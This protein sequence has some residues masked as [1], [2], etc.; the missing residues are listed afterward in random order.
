[1]NSVTEQNS[2]PLSA[3]QIKKRAVGSFVSMLT[4]EGIVGLITIGGGW[5]LALWLSPADFGTFA[6]IQFLG[7]L[8]AF[9][10]EIGFGGML[11]RKQTEPESGELATIFTLQMAAVLSFALL[12]FLSAAPLAQ[13]FK[14][15]E[16]GTN[17]LH[18]VT[19]SLVFSSLGTVPGALL[20]R[21]LEFNKL[22]LM[23]VL[24]AATF[25]SVALISVGVFNL[26]GWSFGL[27]LVL[28]SLV[29]GF[30]FYFLHPWRPRLGFQKAAAL[31]LAR[32]GIPYQMSVVAAFSKDNST[33]L[34][35]GPLLGPAALGYLNFAL[36]LSQIPAR[37]GLLVGRIAFPAF[38][39]LQDDKAR[40]K[41][42]VEQ[43]LKFLLLT[44]G[45]V[46]LMMIATAPRL[47][48]LIYTDKWS[49]A[50]V[51]FILFSINML[52][53][54]VTTPLVPM[55]SALGYPGRSAR[56]MLVWSA[57]T[58]LIGL[59]LIPSLGL[60]SLAA[61]ICLTTSVATVWCI[62]EV[63]RLVKFDLWSAIRVPFFCLLPVTIGL[64]FSNLWVTQ[65]W[66]LV[67]VLALGLVVH[68]ALAFAL[69]GRALLAEARSIIALRKER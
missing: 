31:E 42:G 30:G 21:N 41:I 26:G 40:L 27:A 51:A 39:R 36:S 5:L 45:A 65:L 35:A 58:W 25:Y 28:R 11:V 13:F 12:L 63:Q 23:D 16:T 66:Q 55:L 60:N 56:I 24:E 59:L 6:V 64:L 49:P 34:L 3:G 43:T 8:F 67:L 37:L 32:F 62:F 18:L 50:V 69:D 44:G 54:Y 4:R 53:S 14:M 15:S 17:L 29:T 20:E 19:L 68:T 46:T 2:G 48:Q 1:M 22:A 7:L 9:F 61:S 57:A 47:I 38:S 33:T 52:G 10:T